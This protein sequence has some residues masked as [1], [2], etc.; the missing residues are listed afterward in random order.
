M[1]DKILGSPGFHENNNGKNKYQRPHFRSVG[2]FHQTG[3]HYSME[4]GNGRLAF[5]ACGK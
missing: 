4:P 1:P 5:A 2:F 3:A